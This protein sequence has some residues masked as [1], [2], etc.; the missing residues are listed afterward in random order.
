MSNLVRT[1]LVR[2][3]NSL[4]TSPT[5]MIEAKGPATKVEDD[6]VRPPASVSTRLAQTEP[7]HLR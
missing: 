6:D 1:V 5:R 2:V 3:R 7:T 4:S